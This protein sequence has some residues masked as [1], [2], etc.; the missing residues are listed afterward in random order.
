[1]VVKQSK[2]R[3]NEKYQTTVHI[4]QETTYWPSE[5]L[6]WWE[7]TTHER[8]PNLTQKGSDS[9][10]RGEPDLS[11][12]QTMHCE[13]SGLLIDWQ[14]SRTHRDIE[15]WKCWA[16]DVGHTHTIPQRESYPQII[17]PTSKLVVVLSKGSHVLIELCMEP[18]TSRMSPSPYKREQ[19][20][21]QDIPLSSCISLSIRPHTD[22]IQA[23]NRCSSTH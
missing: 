18:Q 1:M 22:G 7:F 2:D 11:C 21:S 14:W 12:T 23:L 10:I 5:I 13:K 15:Q 19:W 8:I 16:Q 4:K 17:P 6:G 3:Y 9:F 20:C